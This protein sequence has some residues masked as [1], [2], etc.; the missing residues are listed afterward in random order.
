MV[1]K[2]T[3][4]TLKEAS[5]WA[6]DK[7]GKNVTPSNIAYLVNYGRIRKVSG[8]NGST[9][10][11]TKELEAYYETWPNIREQRYKKRLGNGLN[12]RLSFEEYKEAETTKHVHRLHPYKGKFIPQLVEYFLDS[13][14]DKFKTEAVFQRGD[15][16]LDPFCGSGTTL[17]QANEL[18]INAVGVDVSKFNA[19]IANL[20]L[21][22]VPI[23]QVEKTLAQIETAITSDAVSIAARQFEQAL[24]D[25]LYLF[26]KK[27]FPSPEYKYK[28]RSKEIDETEYGAEKTA[29]FL[30]TYQKLRKNFKLP[31][32]EP[33]GDGFLGTWCFLT[34]FREI[35][36]ANEQIDKIKDASLR[37]MARLVLSRAVRSSRA[38]THYDLATLYEP[39]LETYYCAKH[40]KICKPIFSMLGW[41]HRYSKDTV[42][43]L[44]QF[45]ELRTQTEQICVTGDGRTV[46]LIAELKKA[47]PQLAKL[48]DNQKFRGIFTSPP[49]VGL[50]NYH[51]QHAYA[52]ELFDY[53]RDEANEIGILEKGRGKQAQNEYIA[54]VADVLSHCRQFMVDDFDVFLVANDK[55]GLYPEIANRAKMQIHKEYRRPVINRAEGNKGIYGESIFHIRRH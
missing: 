17:V 24:L 30:P 22:R 45:E 37:D 32:I 1:T 6:T 10:V 2:D 47:A 41:W 11:S 26:N 5:A 40:G 3:T 25:E 14:T 8:E 55:F 15:L 12:W 42:K 16:V 39:T 18:G 21:A 46:D 38:T 29:L 49:Y 51:E 27:Y 9:A 54:G 50:I 19:L 52:Y 34:V 4:L 48:A 35:Q 44:T 23:A 20:K 7:L 13:H 43:R 53:E 28:V 36:I 33:T 31:N